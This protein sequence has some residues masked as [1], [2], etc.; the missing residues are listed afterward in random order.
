[1]KSILFKSALFASLFFAILG[2]EK[3]Q[4]KDTN[5]TA[6]KTLYEPSQGKSLVLQS[7]ASAT[8]Y[9][10]WEPAKAEDGGMV[11]YEVAFDVENGDFSQPVYKMA[12]D[13]NGGY[14]YATITHKQLNKI[15]EMAGIA[16][17]ATGKLRWTVFSSKGINE[18][19]AEET[20]ILEITRLAGFA[21]IPVDV[22]VSGDGS[23]G[24][25]DLASAKIMK[26]IAP[27]EYEVY[28][29]LTTGKAYHFTDAKTGTPRR[30]YVENNL[31]KEGTAS[32]NVSKTAVY[33]INLDFNIGSAVYT[34]INK[35][36]L[37][38]SPTNEFLFTHDYIGEGIWKASS[39]PITFKQE[40]WG[41]DERYKIRMTTTNAAGET[42]EEWW[43]TPNTDHRPTAASPP[44]YYF[45]YRVDNSRW[46]GK[47]K[48]GSDID[49]SLA[50][51]TMSSEER[52]VG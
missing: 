5:V 47:F 19:I 9:F 20:R 23:E 38:F 12:S 49:M 42:V 8:L 39:K 6:V 11:L 22:Y 25:T 29:K 34:E 26:A 3:D 51:V 1:M 18:K 4:L 40:S 10:E 27:G 33:R 52:R 46:N 28:T 16:S 32:S 17:A 36:E 43:G 50:D 2:C 44:S 31:L 24:G 21:D 41:R 48:F 14:N 45:L 37:F 30:F 35:I 13:N 15:G 7:S